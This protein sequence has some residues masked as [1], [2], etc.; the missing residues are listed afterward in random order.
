MIGCDAVQGSDRGRTTEPCEVHNWSSDHDDRC[1]IAR[2]IHDVPQQA[3]ALHF[4][5][6]QTDVGYML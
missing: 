4:L 3:R 1:R 6:L 2:R 5:L